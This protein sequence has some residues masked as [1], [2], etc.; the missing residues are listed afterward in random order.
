VAGNANT[1]NAV[2]LVT[3]FAIGNL[4]TSPVTK[5]YLVVI[6]VT[7]SAVTTVHQNVCLVLV[8]K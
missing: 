4:A 2:I 1:R 7:A 8:K 5:S 3:N 6:Y